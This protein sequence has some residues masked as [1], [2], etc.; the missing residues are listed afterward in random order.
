MTASRATTLGALLVVASCYDQDYRDP[1]DPCPLS[2]CCEVRVRGRV[3]HK[4][5]PTRDYRCFEGRC[6]DPAAGGGGGAG[7]TTTGG[8]AGR[9]AG[10]DVRAAGTGG[11]G[12]DG[13]A[14]VDAL[15]AAGARGDAMPADASMGGAG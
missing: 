8:R 12:G 2:E 15:A 6:L 13:D 4:L 14:T 9:D 10:V 11:V 1:G 3:E 5:C 7:A